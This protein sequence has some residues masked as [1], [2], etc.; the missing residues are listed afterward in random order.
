MSLFG[1]K[2]SLAAVTRV[3]NF[4]LEISTFAESSLSY[5]LSPLHKLKKA[6]SQLPRHLQNTLMARPL[7][8]CMNTASPPIPDMHHDN[9]IPIRGYSE[10]NN[11][12]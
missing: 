3:L 8:G 2:H 12:P 4:H 11:F 1:V 5:A 7:P 10:R 6:S 9:G